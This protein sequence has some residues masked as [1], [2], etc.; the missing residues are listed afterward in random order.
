ML[1]GV[2]FCCIFRVIV[3][4]G[5]VLGARFWGF[6]AEGAEITDGMTVPELQYA[7]PPALVTYVCECPDNEVILVILCCRFAHTCYNVRLGEV[8]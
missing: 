2:A 6:T 1:H 3:K 4:L 5:G 7:S 8:L